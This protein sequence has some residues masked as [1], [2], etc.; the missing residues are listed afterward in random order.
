[1]PNATEVVLMIRTEETVRYIVNRYKIK[2]TLED[3]INEH[4]DEV[5]WAI[6]PDLSYDKFDFSWR[7]NEENFRHINVFGNEYS[8]NTQTYYVNGPLYMMGHKEFNYVEGQTVEIDSNLSMFYI[9]RS[10]SE[11]NERF[12]ALKVRYPQIQKTRYLNTWV[13]TINRCINKSQT[14]LCWI[15]NSEIDYSEFEFD[16]YPSPWQ[17][18]MVHVFGTQWSHWGTTFM[19]NKESFPEDTKYVKIIEHLNNLNFVKTKRAF[20]SNCIY[21]VYLIDYGNDSTTSIT[22]LIENKNGNMEICIQPSS[23][24]CWAALSSPFLRLASCFA[25]FLINDSCGW[26]IS[27]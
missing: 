15:L 22:S 14:K 11:S 13:D 19:V 9:D 24:S 5:F 6:N 10:N 18:K 4:P 20:A 26:V 2:T 16:F 25:F 21:D 12:N 17:E 3:L 23:S 1:M 7:P 27:P 8:K